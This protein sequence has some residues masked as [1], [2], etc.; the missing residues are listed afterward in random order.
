M[1]GSFHIA[2]YEVLTLCL[3]GWYA[4][5]TNVSK[6]RST[7]ILAVITTILRNVDDY[8]SARY[9]SPQYLS[10]QSLHPL[11]AY[12]S[13]KQFCRANHGLQTTQLSLCLGTAASGCTYQQGAQQSYGTSS[14]PWRHGVAGLYAVIPLSC[15]CS[16]CMVNLS[17]LT[18]TPYPSAH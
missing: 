5:L 4:V 12:F 15:G 1:N 7:S 14:S 18:V 16:L 3:L 9:N 8:W 13:C 6:I 2:R 17:H 11:L 10:P